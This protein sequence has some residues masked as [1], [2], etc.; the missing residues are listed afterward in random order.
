MSDSPNPTSNR[1][2]Y[3]AGILGALVGILAIVLFLFL[4]LVLNDVATLPRLVIA[5]CVPPGVMTIIIGGY[6]LN[7][8][9]KK[10]KKS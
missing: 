9:A 3:R 1:S 10:S 7:M 8:Q 4:W 6:I 5:V 2:Y